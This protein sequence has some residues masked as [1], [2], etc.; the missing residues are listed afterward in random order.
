[1][2]DGPEGVGVPGGPDIALIRLGRPFT[3]RPAG[4]QSEG[5]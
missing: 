5:G 3:T 4:A 2:V 1:M